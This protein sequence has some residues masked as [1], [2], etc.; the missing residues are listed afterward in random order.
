MIRV[1]R[2]QRILLA[3]VLLL[4]VGCASVTTVN[5]AELDQLKADRR[6]PKVNHWYYMGNR[7][8]F[9]YFHHSD[10]KRRRL[11]GYE[12]RIYLGPRVSP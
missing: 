12:R 11:I 4:L 5:R 6:E 10:L 7:D 2:P 9:E 8:G 3:V 1:V